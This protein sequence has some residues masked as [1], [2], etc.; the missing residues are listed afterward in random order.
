MND[1]WRMI[2]GENV[3]TVVML[4]NFI[5]NGKNRCAKYWSDEGCKLFD[6]LVVSV[7]ATHKL[8][9]YTVRSMTVSLVCG[10]KS[11]LECRV[12]YL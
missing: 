12:N 2:W 8:A 4:A 7:D 6:G 3:S 11:I 1:M 5:E 9:Y 10:Q